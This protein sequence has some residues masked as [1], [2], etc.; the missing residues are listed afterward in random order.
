M[1]VFIYVALFVEPLFPENIIPR[2]APCRHFPAMCIQ[3]YTLVENTFIE[4]ISRKYKLGCFQCKHFATPPNDKNNSLEVLQ[5][6]PMCLQNRTGGCRGFPLLSRRIATKGSTEASSP[7]L[8]VEV[9][10]AKP[11]FLLFGGV[12]RCYKKKSMNV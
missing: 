10:G 5:F 1:K 9:R 7:L 11:P 2:K 6:V 3:G 4:I 12:A 8:S